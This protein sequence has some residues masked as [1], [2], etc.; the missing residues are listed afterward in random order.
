VNLQGRNSAECVAAQA[1][2]QGLTGR[3]AVVIDAQR[4][5][6]YLANYALTP[7]SWREIE[8]LRLASHAMV[9]ECEKK[10]DVLVGSEVTNWFPQGRTIFPR[11]TMLGK[12]A[13]SSSGVIAAEK[14]E[15]I[16]LRMTNFV[17]APPSR[18]LPE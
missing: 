1:H 18:I 4:G 10:G 6:F 16:Y 13:L 15:P 2:A 11:A 8:M 12:L 7:S 3:I 17:K 9:T 5:E 14:L